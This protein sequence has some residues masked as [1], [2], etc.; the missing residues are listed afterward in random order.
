MMCM[1]SIKEAGEI[2][3]EHTIVVHAIVAQESDNR[4]VNVLKS[5]RDRCVR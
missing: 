4:Q 3:I 2:G 5:E 1:A